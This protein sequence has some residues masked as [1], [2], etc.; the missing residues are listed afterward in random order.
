[1]ARK[2]YSPGGIVTSTVER[3]SRR[4]RETVIGVVGVAVLSTGSYFLVN[5]MTDDAHT[6]T[7]QTGAV[8][9][10]TSAAQPTSSPAVSDS[11]PAS[12]LA[13]PSAA[14]PS[15]PRSGAAK[16]GTELLRPPSQQRGAAPPVTDDQLTVTR[17]G[18]LKTDGA[19]LQVVSARLDLT[20]QRELTWA[21]DEGLP[22]GDARCTQKFRFSA[23]ASVVEKPTLLLCWRTSASRSVYT[24]A[25]SVKGPPSADASIAAI[26]QRWA[27]LG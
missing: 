23:G 8:A 24:I 7:P 19:A 16:S 5:A 6:G 25:T 1:M 14:P 13:S 11:A 18:N 9:Q 27:E 4:R 22:V 3:L 15:A 26:N 20:G 21:A 10:R 17:S 2:S 12:S